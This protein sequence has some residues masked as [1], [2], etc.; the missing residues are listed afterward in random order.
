MLCAKKTAADLSRAT[1]ILQSIISRYLSGTIQPKRDN[2][3]AISKYLNVNETWLMGLSNDITR[4]PIS[5][6]NKRDKINS[7]LKELDDQDLDVLA[8][9]IE[10]MFRNK[11][12][13]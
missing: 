13:R 6:P 1:G 7:Y 10:N 12:S 5:S 2:T 11:I 9:I 3:T 8:I 4:E